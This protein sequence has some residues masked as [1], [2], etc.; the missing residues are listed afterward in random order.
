MN[1]KPNQNNSHGLEREYSS[2]DLLKK[3]RSRLR[4]KF[5]NVNLGLERTEFNES[6]NRMVKMRSVWIEKIR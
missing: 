4:D 5:Q 3:N 1:Y 6:R 2:E